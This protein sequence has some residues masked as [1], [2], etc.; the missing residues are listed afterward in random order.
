MMLATWC[1]N[2]DEYSGVQAKRYRKLCTS[3]QLP[4]MPTIDCYAKFLQQQ[5]LVVDKK[6]DWSRNVHETWA[7]GLANLRAH[8]LLQL[9]KLS[10]WRGLVFGRQ[11]QLMKDA[12]DQHRVTYGVFIAHK[13]LSHDLE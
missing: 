11:G 1:S 5:G 10:G 12:F 9:F 2:A 8:S 6:V 13:P 4:Y 3:L 7:V